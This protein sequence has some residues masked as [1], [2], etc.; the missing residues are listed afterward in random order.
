[1]EKMAS[2]NGEAALP[3]AQDRLKAEERAARELEATLDSM[4]C[5][6]YASN[7]ILMM[8]CSSKWTFLR[9]SRWTKVKGL[10]IITRY[11]PFLMLITAMYRAFSSST[12]PTDYVDISSFSVVRAE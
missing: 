2:R 7:F 8:V 5:Q 9:Q 4:S 12:H 3:A 6:T 10:Y 1:M 11:I